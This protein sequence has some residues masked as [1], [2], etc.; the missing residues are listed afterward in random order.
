MAAGVDGELVKA[1]VPTLS[2][3]QDEWDA[4]GCR[5]GITHPKLKRS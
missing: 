4:W 2:Q 5:Q 3:Q 1:L